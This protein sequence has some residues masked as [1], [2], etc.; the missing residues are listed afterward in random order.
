MGILEISLLVFIAIVAI[1][2]GV[3]FYI[4]NKKEFLSTRNKVVNCIKNK[5]SNHFLT[6]KEDSELVHLFFDSV[7]CP[8]FTSLM[9][10]EIAKIALQRVNFMSEELIEHTINIIKK[11]NWFIDWDITSSDSI[12]RLLMKK[13]LKAPYGD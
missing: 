12:E 9:K 3:G 1:V 7:R 5:F 6:I 13:E 2:T 4:Q 8:Y 10:Y 11:Q